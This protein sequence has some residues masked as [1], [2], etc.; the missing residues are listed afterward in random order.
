MVI[1]KEALMKI[2]CKDTDKRTAFAKKNSRLRKRQSKAIKAIE[3]RIFAKQVKVI[4]L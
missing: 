2:G 4:K 3:A 1:G